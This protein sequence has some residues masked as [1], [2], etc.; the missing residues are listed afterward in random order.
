MVSL[1][2]MLRKDISGTACGAGVRCAFLFDYEDDTSY[3]LIL[4]QLSAYIH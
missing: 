3:V 1:I 4:K 2:C